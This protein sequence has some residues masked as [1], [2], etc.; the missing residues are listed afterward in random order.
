VSEQSLCRVC[1][2]N[3]ADSFEHVPPRKALNDE[4]SRVYGL[5]DWLAASD[6][7]MTGGRIEQ[8]G[9]GGFYLCGRC[10]NNT[11]SWYGKE[12]VVAAASGARVLRDLPLADLEE[13]LEPAYVQVKFTQSTT[14]PHPLRFI[15]QV[16]TMLLAICPVGFSEKNPDLSAFVLERDRT[17]LDPKY[18]FHLGLFAG[19]NAR[20]V[21][22]SVALDVISGTATFIVEV[23][24]PPF[25][26]VMT[27]DADPER[28]PT[29][30]ITGFV[31]VGY[32]Q[33]ADLEMELLVGFGHTPLPADYRTKAMVARDRA[34]NEAYA[35][36]HGIKEGFI[37]RS[38]A[39]E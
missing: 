22:G 24:Y 10:N 13:T 11:G 35:H 16:V 30:N 1:R 26:Y 38:A 33:R 20:T 31:D 21:G 6:G 29:S 2:S 36:E 3:P 25:A 19:P 23:A 7:E 4:P 14:G 15:K 18:Q 12:L 5:T 9:A 32:K 8:R 17:G 37:P 34:Q 39:S 28:V 27:I